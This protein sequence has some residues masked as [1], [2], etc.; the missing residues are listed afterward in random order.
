MARFL[1][2]ERR[3]STFFDHSMSI[4]KDREIEREELE[5]VTQVERLGQENRRDRASFRGIS[6]SYCLSWTVAG[7]VLV[8]WSIQLLGSVTTYSWVAIIVII[9]GVWGIAAATLCWLPNLQREKF[10][11]LRG[12]AAWATLGLVIGCYVV[13]S[14]LQIHAA[15][16]YG[17]DEIAFDQYAAVLAQHGLDPYVHSMTPSFTLYNVS[18]DG[19]TYHLNGTP[20]STL[21]YPAFSFLPYVPFL[22]LGWSTQLAIVI[23]SLAWC[24]T[25]ALLFVI[26]PRDVRALGLVIGSIAAFGSFA[27]GG[28]TDVFYIPLLIGAT[29]H[30]TGFVHR[31]GMS[32]YIG[33][34]CLGLAMC[35]KQTPW[36]VAPFLFSGIVLEARS[37]RDRRA[38]ARVAG[39]YLCAAGLAFFVPNIPY[40]FMNPAAW[41]RGVLT[42][43]SS[44]IVPSGQGFMGLSLFLHLGGGSIKAYSLLSIVVLALLLEGYI[45]TYPLLRPVTVLFAS[46]VLFFASRSFGSYL[47]ALIPVVIVGAVTTGNTEL[48]SKAMNYG[49]SRERPP[50]KVGKS[51]HRTGILVGSGAIVTVVILALALFTRQPLLLRVTGVRTTGQL[52]TVE[53]LQVSVT[54]TSGSIVRPHFTVGEGGALTTFWQVAGGPSSLRPRATATYIL[55]SPNFQAQPSIGG[56]FDV[57]AFTSRPGS[58]SASSPYLPSTEH[59]ALIPAAIN[60]PVQVGTTVKVEAQLL[61][62]FDRPIREAGIPA[63]FGQI[64]YDQLGLQ[65]SEAVINGGLPGQTPVTA[66]TNSAGIATFNIVG[67]QASID[68]VYFEANLV[69]ST[70]YYPYGY[71]QILP[72]RFSK[73]R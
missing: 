26:L 48:R 29:Y 64:I 16:S 3:D 25:T 32:R 4:S 2:G 57:V 58:V 45:F 31:R 22:L 71:S 18:P 55:R 47:F 33:P 15:P 39:S 46:F 30:W 35:V 7:A 20:V 62:Q 34:V 24:A 70:E 42:P 49:I 9:S 14:F 43:F 72:I 59:L 38:T 68:P 11:C 1:F 54:N 21:S 52:A 66:Y 28:V 19:F 37:L 60:A 69:S 36:L 51:K 27:L 5:D 10:K 53:Q 73:S 6:L 8:N 40:I 63:Y 65:Y 50:P 13:W 41:M 44:D 56:G 12:V 61:D 67:T 23:N 17:T